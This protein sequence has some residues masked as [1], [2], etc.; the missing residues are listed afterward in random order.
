[1]KNT[2]KHLAIIAL[3]STVL[4]A[5]AA[6]QAYSFSGAMDSGFYNGEAFS[7]SFTFD[8][9]MVDSVGLDITS[10]LSLNMSFLNKNFTIV[11]STA[12]PDV[13]FQDGAFLGLSWSVDSPTPNIG[14]TFNPGI[15]GVDEAYVAYDTSAGLSGAGSVIYQAVP[16]PDAYAML[17]AG[18]G[19]IG[20]SA[21]RKRV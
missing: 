6:V 5:Q 15:T 18:L 1:M 4:P 21:R 20:F 3:L 7:G 12:T 17:L 10:L 13:S 2:I 11:N 14:F 16:E 9:T 8:D 19:L